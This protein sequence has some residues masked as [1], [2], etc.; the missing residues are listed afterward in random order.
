[1]AIIDNKS[2]LQ[3][4]YSGIINIP[5]ST[6]SIGAGIPLD[7]E[8]FDNGLTLFVLP[9]NFLDPADA[10]LVNLLRVQDSADN[11]VFNDVNANQFIGSIANFQN[12]SYLNT[13][14]V[15][16]IPTL[17]MIGTR[18]FVRVLFS[19]PA[20]AGPVDVAHGYMAGIEEKPTQNL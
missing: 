7:T 15:L 6:P 11:I 12:L 9:T 18:R 13:I 14:N 5:P 2:N 1:M 20:N 10:F 17:G 16:T 8:G 3:F 19:T 4:I